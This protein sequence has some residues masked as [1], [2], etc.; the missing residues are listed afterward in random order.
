MGLLP[1]VLRPA[2]VRAVLRKFTVTEMYELALDVA[3]KSLNA[4][5][6]ERFAAA[7]AKRLLDD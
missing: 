7:L 2:E 6:Y 1:R 5:Q 4:S 3:K